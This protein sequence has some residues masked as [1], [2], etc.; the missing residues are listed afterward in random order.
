MRCREFL[1]LNGLTRNSLIRIGQNVRVSVENSW[2]LVQRGQT[3]CGI[4]E[5]Y[6]VPCADLLDANR[7][8]RSS[9]IRIGQ[10]LRIP[11]RI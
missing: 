3:A 8:R 9:T 5:S 6:R 7:L 2:H 4:A 11:N 1:A 10:R